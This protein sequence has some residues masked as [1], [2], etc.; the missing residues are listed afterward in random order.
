MTDA[1]QLM[2]DTK[3]HKCP[4]VLNLVWVYR[5][6]I[7][8]FGKLLQTLVAGALCSLVYIYRCTIHGRRKLL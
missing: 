2:T 3:G 5:C 4:L 7:F 8:Y 1:N 6:P